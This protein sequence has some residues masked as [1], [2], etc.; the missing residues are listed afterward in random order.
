[1]IRAMDNYPFLLSSLCV[2]FILRVLGQLAVSI[3]VGTSI[4]PPFSE[5]QSGLLPYPALLSMQFFVIVLYGKIITD[6]KHRSG[7][8]GI[9]NKRLGMS[10]T[11]CGVLYAA[12]M[13][14][15]YAVQMLLFPDMR[16]F[17]GTIPIVFHLVLATSLMI[18]GNY[19]TRQFSND[20]DGN[21]RTC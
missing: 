11:I 5:W 20:N 8:F 15:R 2:L 14:A 16:W 10:L 6:I 17:G 4:L 7:L 12:A 1:M 21:L 3:G 13:M 19:H 18:A 9:A